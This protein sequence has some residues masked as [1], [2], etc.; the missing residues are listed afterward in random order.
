MIKRVKI[1]KAKRRLKRV[2]NQIIVEETVRRLQNS[3]TKK[4]TC[5]L[6]DS[7]TVFEI[8]RFHNLR[9]SQLLIKT[10]SPFLSRNYQEDTNQWACDL[11]HIPYHQWRFA[12]LPSRIQDYPKS[13]KQY[14]RKFKN[15]R[16]IKLCL[17]LNF[18]H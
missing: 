18:D 14:D 1:W 4:E 11:L 16:N 3:N 10:F 9:K 2:G 6:S 12:L 15:P 17:L 7:R 13:M 8:E 5:D